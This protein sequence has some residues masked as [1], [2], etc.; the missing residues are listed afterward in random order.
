ML[1]HIISST[2]VRVCVGHR[3]T[4]LGF[5]VVF[6]S[7]PPYDRVSVEFFTYLQPIAE[8]SVIFIHV[9]IGSHE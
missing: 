4:S 5:S 7:E 2:H 9:D 3:S 8:P 6:E 1:A